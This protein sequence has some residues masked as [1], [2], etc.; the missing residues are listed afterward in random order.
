VYLWSRPEAAAAAWLG[1]HSTADD[2]VLAST[3]FANPLIGVIDG[4]TVHGHIV[5]TLR[6]S[7]KE[8]L[9]QRFYAE[10]TPSERALI[11]ADSKAT[12]VA[13]GPHERAMGATDLGLQ[14]GLER[15]Y[16]RDGVEFFR[17]QR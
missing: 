3:A 13:F 2:V 5:A 1:E 16:D 7:E 11:L 17:V 14:P 9:V 4:R 15:I 8:A 12:L 6:S 10:I